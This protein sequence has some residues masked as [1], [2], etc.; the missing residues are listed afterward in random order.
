MRTGGAT[1]ADAIPEVTDRMLQDGLGHSDPR[2][3]ERY[4]RQKQRNAQTV[5]ALRQKMIKTPDGPG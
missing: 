4:R 2:T 5:V 1:E 3:K